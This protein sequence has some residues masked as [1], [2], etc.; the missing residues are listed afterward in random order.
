LETHAQNPTCASCH[1]HTDP[2]GLSLEHFDAIGAYRETDNGLA[3]DDTGKLDQA[4]FQGLMGL[5]AVLRDHAALG[6]CLIQSF[7]HVAIGRVSN[8]FDREPF[9]SLADRFHPAG[10]RIGSLLAAITAS[11]G[12]RYV[13]PPAQN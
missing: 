6:P 4:S 3:I 9:G 11:D 7:Y 10:A 12:F 13:P 5:A 2:V 8:A 1:S